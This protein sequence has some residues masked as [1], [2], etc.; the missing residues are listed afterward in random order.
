MKIALILSPALVSLASSLLAAQ[1][2]S[3]LVAHLQAGKRQTLVAYGTSLTANGAWV[4]QL[5][6]ILQRRYPGLAGERQQR[7][8]GLLVAVG[9]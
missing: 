4:K 1:S 2:T 5:Q 3:K 9:S 6:A 8:L 7:R